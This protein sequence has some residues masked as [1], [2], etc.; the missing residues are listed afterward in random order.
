MADS[1]WFSWRN[2]PKKKE[3]SMADKPEEA[4]STIGCL[5]LVLVPRWNRVEDMGDDSKAV[6]YRCYA[7]GES[8]SPAEAAEARAR[9][10]QEL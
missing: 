7:C 1:Q 3:E 6:G 10:R 9:S 8:L 4:H 5:H 2:R